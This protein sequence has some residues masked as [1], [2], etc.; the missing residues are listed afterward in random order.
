MA[1]RRYSLWRHTQDTFE[2]LAKRRVRIVANRLC[3]LEHFPIIFLQRSGRLVHSP[4]R[5]I[6]EWSFPQQFF[7]SQYF[8]GKWVC[9]G[10]WSS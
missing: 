6:F 3:D 4:V 2:S 10:G 5:Q 9:K 1:L 7:K 8:E